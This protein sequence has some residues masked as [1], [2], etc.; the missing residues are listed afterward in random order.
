MRTPMERASRWTNILTVSVREFSYKQDGGMCMAKGL[1]NTRGL[2][3]C[4]YGI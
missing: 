1:K 4:C 2:L 3:G